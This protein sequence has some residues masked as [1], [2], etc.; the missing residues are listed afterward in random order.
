LH[1]ILSFA[2]RSLKPALLKRKTDLEA[3]ALRSIKPCMTARRAV[4]DCASRGPLPARLPQGLGHA[5]IFINR[6]APT[7]RVPVFAVDSPCRMSTVAAARGAS[8]NDAIDGVT[9]SG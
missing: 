1:P 7:R 6:P 9:A 4:Q 8:R 3:Q 2:R 5:A